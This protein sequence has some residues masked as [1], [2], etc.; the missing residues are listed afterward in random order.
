MILAYFRDE[1]DSATI[2]GFRAESEKASVTDSGVTSIPANQD[3]NIRLFGN[4]LEKD[5]RVKF[6][7]SVRE[8]GHLC[9]DV[10]TTAPVGPKLDVD[11]DDGPVVSVLLTIN[12]PEH[13]SDEKFYIC[14]WTSSASWVHQGTDKSVQLRTFGRILPVPVHII[15]LVVLLI[16]SGLFSGLNLGLMALDRTELKIIENC[17][18]EK[19]KKH[20]RLI[21]P[22][23]KLGNYLLCSLLLGNVLVNSTLTIL[24]DLLTSGLVAIIGSTFGIVIFGEIIP[25]AICSRHGLAVGARTV[26]I[27][28]F[29]MLVTFPLSFPISK[30]LDLILGEEIGNV[31][32]RERLVELI[33][34]TKDFNELEKDEVSNLC[35]S[36]TANGQRQIFFKDIMSKVL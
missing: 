23:R 10:S 12:L 25:Q 4:H 35:F 17:G 34:V 5:V 16:L 20:A 19:E 3:V 36:K 9:D 30:I 8:R 1:N 26:W 15:L 31:Y 11:N 32:N 14:L 29:F 7:T 24:L 22:I 6:T 33:R 2:A 28:K 21:S 18:S 13:G 27:T